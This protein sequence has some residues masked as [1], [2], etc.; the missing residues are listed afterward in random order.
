M[1]GAATRILCGALLG[2]VLTGGAPGAALAAAPSAD[3]LD[4][5][6]ELAL[7]IEPSSGGS[8]AEVYALFDGEV[9]ESLAGG[10]PFASPAFLEDRLEAFAEAWGGLAVRVLPLARATVAAFS[11]TE[12][13]RGSAVRVYGKREGRAVL[14]ATLVGEGWPV[15]Q[16][17]PRSRAGPAQFLVTWEG[18]P[19]SGAVRPLRFDVV[20]EDTMGVR[21]TWTSATDFP[22]GLTARWYGARGSVITV[23]HD[24]HHPGWAP[25]CDGQTEWEDVYRLPPG[26]SAFVRASRRELNGWHRE[27]HAAAEQ[28]F[29]ALARSDRAPLAALV[30]DAALRVRLP[31]TLRPDPAC[32][33][34]PARDGRVSIP[35]VAGPRE[36]WTLTFRREGGRWRLIAAAPIVL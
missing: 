1:T 14:L 34:P 26:A 12:L 16:P 25:G 17:L 19:A 21:V 18:P 13:P 23:R 35:A 20:R 22:D 6:R 15:L 36:P 24:V 8:L 28:L 11:F 31:A 29:A 33:G 3:R 2:G 32:D 30:P 10:G 27:V 7:A 9:V 5:F 4:R